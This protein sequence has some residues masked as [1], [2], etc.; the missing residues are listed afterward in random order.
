MKEAIVHDD[1]IRKISEE[2]KENCQHEIEINSLFS[3]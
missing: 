2:K 1:K 3:H